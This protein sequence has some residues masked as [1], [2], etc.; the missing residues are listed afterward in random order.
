MGLG[1][2]IKREFAEVLPTASQYVLVLRFQNNT[3]KITEFW[4][5]RAAT[6]ISFYMSDVFDG[7]LGFSW[8]P[9]S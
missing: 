8:Q 4:D 3:K 6:L 9:C 5:D 2:V 7:S 1:W